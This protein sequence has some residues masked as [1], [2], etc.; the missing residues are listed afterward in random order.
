MQYTE[1]SRYA[2]AGSNFIGHLESSVTVSRIAHLQFLREN[3]QNYYRDL[4]TQHQRMQKHAQ[5][6]NQQCGFRTGP[7]Q[8]DLYKHIK[9]LEA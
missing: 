4:N 7:T 1:I 6:E 3:Q 5:S 2:K 9:E 8:T